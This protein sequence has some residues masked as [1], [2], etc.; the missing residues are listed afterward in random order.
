MDGLKT[1]RIQVTRTG[2]GSRHHVSKMCEYNTTALASGD[3][4]Y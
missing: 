4:F 1:R 2:I 3:Y